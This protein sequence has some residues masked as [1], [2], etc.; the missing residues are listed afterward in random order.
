MFV[1]QTP[2]ALGISPG[3]T[4]TSHSGGRY[5]QPRLALPAATPAS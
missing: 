5:H 3:L 2:K 4:F 1:T